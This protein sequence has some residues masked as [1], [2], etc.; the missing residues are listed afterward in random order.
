MANLQPTYADEIAPGLPG[1]QANSEPAIIISRTLLG[2][3]NVGPGEMVFRSA[4]GDADYNDHGAKA[5]TG[6]DATLL[7]GLAKRDTTLGA[8]R[9]F[10]RSAANVPAGVDPSGDTMAI[11]T[12]GVW[13]VKAGV[14]LTPADPVFFNTVTKRYV[15]AAGANIIPVANGEYED[16]ATANGDMVRL[17][18]RNRNGA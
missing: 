13:W 17:A 14:A 6:A 5:A 4:P 8:E 16:T 2:A 12:S 11:A 18:L 1:Q 10:Y 3:T 9:D 7:L 15:K